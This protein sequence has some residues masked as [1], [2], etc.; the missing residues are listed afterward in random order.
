MKIS[1][2][3]IY[4]FCIYS[5]IFLNLG[6]LD[7]FGA[8]DRQAMFV[9]ILLGI[10]AFF[11]YIFDSNRRAIKRGRD[12][13][14][15]IFLILCVFILQMF[16]IQNDGINPRAAFITFGGMLLGLATF[17]MYELLMTQFKR[18][19]KY[20]VNIGFAAMILRIILWFFYNFFILILD[21]V[22]LK[23]EKIGHER[24]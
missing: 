19:I 21:E 3:N 9:S 7:V 17:P 11:I 8:L 20:I 16:R 10:F 5:I 1:T 4:E 22:F 6:F 18:T 14:V 13:V 23:E 12:L 24:Y 15:G 2:R